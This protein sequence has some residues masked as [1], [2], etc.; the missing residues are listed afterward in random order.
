M[1]NR[2]E[3]QGKLRVRVVEKTVEADGICSFLLKPVD[4]GSLPAFTPGAHID[5]HL[6]NG[7]TRQYSLCSDFAAG[8]HYQIA[9]LREPNSRGGS[10]AMHDTVQ[11]GAVLTVSEPRN[12]FALDEGSSHCLLMAGGIGITPLLSMTHKLLKDRRSFD[13]HY[14]SRSLSRMA[15]A[16]RIRASELAHRAQLHLDD[17]PPEQ[18]LDVRAILAQAPAGTHLFVCGPKG[19]IDHV[20]GTAKEVGW[21]LDRIHF[22]LFGAPAST[23][24]AD[25]SFEVELARSSRTV[26]V[27]A[28]QTILE[29]LRAAGLDADTSCEQGVY[30]T[31]LTKVLSGTCDHRDV[32]LTQAEQESNDQILLCVSR[33][34]TLRLVLD[35]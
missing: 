19:Y 24:E 7:L 27:P 32:Y 15:F 14:S 20:T 29:A 26:H 21:P 28:N 6:E 22:E 1:V 16:E 31:C 3:S 25:G 8:D 23:T 18:A 5:V 10:V 33:A 34:K 4:A 9:V 30:G 12:H 13:L 2:S 17:G 35:L 11:V